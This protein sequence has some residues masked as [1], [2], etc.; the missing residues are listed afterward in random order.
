[1]MGSIKCFRESLFSL[2]L[3]SCSCTWCCFWG[4]FTQIGM[5]FNWSPT[6]NNHHLN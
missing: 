6:W 2:A 3:F 1:L 4:L 5:I